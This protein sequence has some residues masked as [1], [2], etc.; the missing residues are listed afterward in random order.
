[1]GQGP[2]GEERCLVEL[3]KFVDSRLHQL[4]GPSWGEEPI[5]PNH[6]VG[7][8][9][10]RVVLI[11]LED[12]SFAIPDPELRIGAHIRISGLEA[13]LLEGIV[14]D[15][16]LLDEDTRTELNALR[17]VAKWIDSERAPANMIGLLKDGDVDG[18][19]MLIRELPEVVSSG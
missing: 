4:L 1:M 2:E 8:P 19:A 18:N 3:E 14:H 17:G 7:I 15:V 6:L 13:E 12:E 10:E 11:D 5:L 9:P 16:I